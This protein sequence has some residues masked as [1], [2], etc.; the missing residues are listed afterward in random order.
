MPN[1]FE[2]LDVSGD[3][4]I[5]AFGRSLPE[6]FVNAALGMYSLITDTDDI[7]ERMGV[8]ITC[9]GGSL[10]DLLI[11]WL[12]ELI[13]QFDTYGFMGRKITVTAFS[14]DL[15]GAPEN[16]SCSIKASLR[17]EEFDP[18]RSERKLLVKAATY[19]KLKLRKSGDRWESEVIF[20]I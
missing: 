18:E 5:R 14:P 3:A 13:F 15:D 16:V 8:E 17:G 4:G 2:A 20:D 11:K 6:L 9:E 19:H 12:N 1:D 7:G 10:E